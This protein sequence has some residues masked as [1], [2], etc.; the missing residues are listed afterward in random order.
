MHSH[1]HQK[2]L[3][4]LAIGFAFWKLKK[5]H[6]DL[7]EE[8]VPS[9]T[10]KWKQKKSPTTSNFSRSPRCGRW[11]MSSRQH[12]GTSCWKWASVGSPVWV[13][14]LFLYLSDLT[15]TIYILKCSSPLGVAGRG[16]P[17]LLTWKHLMAHTFSSGS[18]LGGRTRKRELWLQ[19][20]AP[21]IMSLARKGE[22][23]K[24]MNNL[25][26][27]ERR[28]SPCYFAGFY[29]INML[30]SFTLAYTWEAETKGGLLLENN[31]SWKSKKCV[32]VTCFPGKLSNFCQRTLISINLEGPQLPPPPQQ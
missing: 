19:Q 22:C 4:Q 31:S 32:P 17:M 20:E 28:A 27:K 8:E 24:Q 30:C 2:K 15:G 7:E 29:P 26:R 12:S 13:R 6:N 1:F 23:K 10:H 5:K 14:D 16:I 11:Q 18:G 9:V 3:L 21:L 25:K